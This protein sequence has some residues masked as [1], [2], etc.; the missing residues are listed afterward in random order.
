MTSSVLKKANIPIYYNSSFNDDIILVEE[1]DIL[2]ALTSL[3]E[4]FSIK[5]QITASNHLAETHLKKKIPY[6]EN[7]INTSENQKQVLEEKNITFELKAMK[8]EILLLK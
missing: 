8:K 1:K 5:I 7:T 2:K 3:S 6:Q 4:H